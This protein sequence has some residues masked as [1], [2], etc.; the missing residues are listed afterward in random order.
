MRNYYLIQNTATAVILG[1]YEGANEAEALDAMA[2]DAGYD[3][4]ADALALNSH[5][6]DNLACE[7]TPEPMIEIDAEGK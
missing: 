6:G 4:Y 2:I 3:S 5:A 1:T 7:L